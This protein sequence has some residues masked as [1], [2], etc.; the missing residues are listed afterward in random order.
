[1]VQTGAMTSSPDDYE[2]L[3]AQIEAATGKPVNPLVPSP[4]ATTPASTKNVGE[5]GK[6]AGGRIAFGAIAGV[7]LGVGGWFVGLLLPFFG[8]GAM[9]LGAAGAAFITALIAGPPRW[10]SS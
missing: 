9:G 10:F 4:Q 1:M 5:A 3:L 8:A 2:K 7:T 6:G